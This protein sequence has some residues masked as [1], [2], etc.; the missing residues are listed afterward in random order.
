MNW[1]SATTRLVAALLAVTMLCAVVLRPPGAMLSS[2]NDT[3]SYVI[4][5]GLG[6]KTVEVPVDGE[7][8]DDT[9]SACRFFA[10]QIA[11]LLADAP[12]VVLAGRILERRVKLPRSAFSAPSLFRP[13]YDTRG[14]PLLS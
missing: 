7:P 5:T 14:P 8:T 4:C 9:D 6:M 2:E 11:A 1:A 12:D 10:T 13:P 3:L